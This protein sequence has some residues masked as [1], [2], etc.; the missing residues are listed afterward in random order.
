M[1]VER[2]EEAGRTGRDDDVY[3]IARQ[4][5]SGID[6]ACGGDNRQAKVAQQRCQ[7][8]ERAV[9]DAGSRG[10]AVQHQGA[11]ATVA[12]QLRQSLRKAVLLRIRFG[13]QHCHARADPQVDGIGLQGHAHAHFF[14][15]PSKVSNTLP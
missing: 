5:R 15:K 3:F 13:A 10:H 8:V 12:G 6:A 11:Q 9:K 4:Q 2:T 7:P 14:R 1:G